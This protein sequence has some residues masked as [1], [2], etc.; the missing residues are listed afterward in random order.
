MASIDDDNIPHDNWGLNLLVNKDID[1]DNYSLTDNTV[2]VFDPLSP[3]NYSYLWHRGYPLELIHKKNNIHKYKKNIL[4]DIQADFW[5]GDPDIDAIERMIY[6]PSCIF[7]DD[8]FPFTSDL[9]SPFNSQNTF[10][11]RK[12][13]QNYFMFPNTGRMEDIWAAYYCIA[14]GNKVVYNKASVTQERNPHN[15]LHDFNAELIG[16]QNNIVLIE[17]LKKDPD[18]IKNFISDNSYK[19]LLEYQTYFN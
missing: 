10:L 6:S 17:A 11:T 1:V 13:L 7:N 2:T 8:P 3:T 5:N 14:N 9:I 12:A 18:N 15:Y 19:A 16:Y 4:A